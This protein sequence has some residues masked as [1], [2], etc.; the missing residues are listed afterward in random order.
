MIDPAEQ[1]VIVPIRLAGEWYAVRVES[2]LEVLKPPPLTVV[3]NVSNVV[4][5]V[6]NIRGNI[7]SV[8]DLRRLLGIPE[9]PLTADSRIVVVRAAGKTTGLLADCVGSV[10]NVPEDSLQPTLSTIPERKSRYVSAELAL[11]D[12]RL[13]AVLNLAEVMDSEEFRGNDSVVGAS[14]G[15]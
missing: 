4:L 2:V 1:L 8:V 11:E 9:S 3:P 13:L 15:P 14:V 7:T 5:G 6:V 10:T 12:G